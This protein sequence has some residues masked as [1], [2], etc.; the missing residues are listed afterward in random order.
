MLR[1]I[2]G[3]SCSGK[4]AYAEKLAVSLKKEHPCGTLYYVATMIP[5]DA[6]CKARIMRHRSMR[7]GKGFVTKEQ[8]V[9]L[10]AVSAGSEDVLLIECL[11]NLL[12]NEL[13]EEGGSLAACV[14]AATGDMGKKDAAGLWDR[15]LQY[16]SLLE[17]HVIQPILH[18]SRQAAEVLVVT[19][20]V[21]SEGLYAYTEETCRYV[22]LLGLLN[23][24]LAK[25]SGTC[26]EVVCG[27]PVER[28]WSQSENPLGALSERKSKEN[29]AVC[30]SR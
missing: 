7:D 19:N 18:L 22:Q 11:S 9:H 8:P 4:S 6:E 26:T 16:P 21:F 30:C 14:M 24:Q 28:N 10:A 29:G 20:E 13:Y 25:L 23:Q 1:L 2:T 27:I 3:A 17:Q 5:Y 12:A 15:D